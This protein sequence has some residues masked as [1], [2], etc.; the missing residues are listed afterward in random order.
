MLK[1]FAISSIYGL[2]ILIPL[3]VT[4]SNLDGKDG[5]S[6]LDNLTI[7]NLHDKSGRF[8]AHAVYTVLLT[9]LIMG[10]LWVEYQ[11]YVTIRD[12]W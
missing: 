6:N 12:E 5:F 7:S 3:D 10:V 4:E 11:H 9:I 1:F 2:A 8:W